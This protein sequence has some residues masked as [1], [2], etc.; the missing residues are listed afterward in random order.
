MMLQASAFVTFSHSLLVSSLPKGL[1]WVQLIS[2]YA[3]VKISDSVE[4]TTI[5][6]T[7]A[8]YTRSVNY[9]SKMFYSTVLS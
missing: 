2:P 5:T 9:D 8:Y 3:C 4:M 7:L 6:N 1:M